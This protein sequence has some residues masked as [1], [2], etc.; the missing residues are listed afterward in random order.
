M[1]FGYRPQEEWGAE[2]HGKPSLLHFLVYFIV[3]T[4]VLSLCTRAG[5]DKEGGRW[6]T[7]TGRDK[8]G[9]SGDGRGVRGR[10]RHRVGAGKS[11][12]FCSMTTAQPKKPTTRAMQ[13]RLP[14][15][16]SAGR[17]RVFVLFF[18]T[19]QCND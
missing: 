16:E 12:L 8:G 6:E 19:F 11:F 3:M 17:A 7:G 14:A 4:D 1:Q 15:T 2:V 10:V 18:S 9:R 5:S 13:V